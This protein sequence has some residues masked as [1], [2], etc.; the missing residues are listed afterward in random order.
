MSPALYLATALLLIVTLLPLWRNT[1]WVIRAMDFPRLQFASFA[2]LLLI[3]QLVCFDLQQNHSWALVMTVATCL[4][5]HLWWIVPYTPAWP[6]EAA[7]ATDAGEDREL[8]IITANVL[9]TN[10]NARP[11]LELVAKNKPDVLLTLE[12]DQWW[13]DQLD[14]LEADM[15][16]TVKCP[17][18]TFTAFTSTLA[19]LYE[20]LRYL[21]WCRKMCLLSTHCLAC[22]A[23]HTVR[24][25][26]FHP[27]PPGP[28]ENTKSAERD[29]ELVMVARSIAKAD[30]PVIV[31]GDLNDVA[32]S[33]T[34]RLF[35]RLS[36]LLD[37]RVGQ[38]YAPT[39]FMLI[40]G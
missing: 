32:W 1:H 2:L 13:Q 14:T 38:R 6:L 31:T 40:T 5:W 39:H 15:P 18:I 12:S 23:G 25:H 27:A 28:A 29:A 36:G 17:W 4:A 7:T 24:M 35:R 16:Y 3:T 9:T 20:T 19:C 11:L 8:S 22:A 33:S 21:L 30:Q 10:R 34:T 37:P 26:C